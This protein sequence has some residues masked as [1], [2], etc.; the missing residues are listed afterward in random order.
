[1]YKGLAKVARDY[2]LGKVLTPPEIMKLK[3]AH[4]KLARTMKTFISSKE[5]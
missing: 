5:I 3:S 2:D 1:M 4:A